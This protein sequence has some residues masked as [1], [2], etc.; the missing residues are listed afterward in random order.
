MKIDNYIASLG[1]ENRP[2]KFGLYFQDSQYGEVNDLALKGSGWYYYGKY[3]PG[4]LFVGKICLNTDRYCDT[5]C[6][7]GINFT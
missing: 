7:K 5:A 1:Y 2:G 3:G 4:Y 6:G